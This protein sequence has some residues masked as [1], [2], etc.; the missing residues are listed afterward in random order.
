M[1]T[2]LTTLN[3]L[4][5]SIPVLLGHADEDEGKDEWGSLEHK[6]GSYRIWVDPT[7][8]EKDRASTIIHELVHLVCEEIYG[9]SLLECQVR[10]LSESMVTFCCQNLD[11]VQGWLTCPGG[12]NPLPHSNLEASRSIH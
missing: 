12:P 7:L 11:Q 5:Y 9:I 4:H 3:F 6:D 2:Q 1:A 10:M 8:S